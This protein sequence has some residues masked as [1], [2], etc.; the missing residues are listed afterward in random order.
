IP[1]L[2][3]FT[4]THDD[5]HRPTDDFDKIDTVGVRR[6]AA[7][8]TGITR[9]VAD[10][11]ARLTLQ[12]GAGKPPAAEAESRGYGAYLGSVP[13]FTPVESGVKLSGVRADSPADKAGIRSGDIIV[14]F[15]TMDIKDLY[16]LT[17]ALRAHKPG[18]S[19]PVTVSRPR[20]PPF[21]LLTGRVNGWRHRGETADN[22][23][24][25]RHCWPCAP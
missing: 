9:T 25:R 5:Y 24:I 16:A 3:F 18:D 23:E 14:R 12:R 17:D 2:M 13:D 19:V 10:R 1:V 6:V 21:A 4:N 20:G 15:G 11:S 7:L 8:V 22:G